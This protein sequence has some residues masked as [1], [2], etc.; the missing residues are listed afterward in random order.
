[1]RR[2][3][4]LI[5]SIV[6][7]LGLISV[8]A[9]ASDTLKTYGYD[10]INNSGGD[11]VIGFL[12]GSITVADGDSGYMGWHRYA[13]RVTE[14]FQ[15][16]YPNKT[17]KQVNAGIGGTGS[18]L[19]K[20]RVM[21]D[22]GAYAPDVVFVEYAV[23]DA[24]YSRLYGESVRSNMETIVRNLQSLPKVPVIVFLYSMHD[25]SYSNLKYTSIPDHQEVADYYDIETINF[26][27]Y[28]FPLVEKGEFIWDKNKVSEGSLTND[29][30]HPNAL[31]HEQYG[32]Y[33][34]SQ[35]ESRDILHKNNTGLSRKFMYTTKDTRD[36]K[37]VDADDFA[38]TGTWDNT[39]AGQSDNKYEAIQA[40]ATGDSISF[41]Y[42]S[43]GN[44]EIGVTALRGS[45]SWVIDEGTENELS[46]TFSV[47]DTNLPVVKSFVSGLAEGEHTVKVV[48]TA[49]GTT[50]PHLKLGR[51]IANG[52][53]EANLS[54]TAANGDHIPQSVPENLVIG[55]QT[56]NFHSD[57]NNG[58]VSYDPYSEDYTGNDSYTVRQLTTS[59][60]LTA[61]GSWGCH[62]FNFAKATAESHKGIL[63]DNYTATAGT[64]VFKARV[65]TLAGNPTIG[66]TT[67]K[68]WVPTYD[69]VYGKDG[70]A[71]GAEWE[72]YKTTLSPTADG[73]TLA[74]GH[75][76]STANDSFLIDVGDGVYFAPEVAYDVRV[77][78][79]GIA[80]E[81]IAG[82]K[83]TYKAELINQIEIPATSIAQD[84]TWSVVDANGAAVEGLTVSAGASTNEA[85]VFAAADV[86]VGTYY[87]KAV[88]TPTLWQKTL[89]IEVVEGAPDPY[90]RDYVP[91]E[92]PENKVVNFEH[93][94]WISNTQADSKAGLSGASW[95]NGDNWGSAKITALED[96][97]SVSSYY[98]S[99]GIY[100][101]TVT[102]AAFPKIEMNS[103]DYLE[104][105]HYVFM[106][107]ARNGNTDIKDTKLRI[108][109]WNGT[110]SGTATDFIPVQE[111]EDGIV[112][113]PD[114]GEWVVVKVTLPER[115]T[116]AAAPSIRMG[117]P[118][119][120]A[121]GTSIELNSKLAG[122]QQAYYAKEVP[123]SVALAGVDGDFVATGG[124]AAFKA[125]LLNQLGLTGYLDQTNVTFT[126]GDAR[127]NAVDGLTVTSSGATATV[128][129]ADDVPEGAYYLRANY[130]I[131]A[132]TTW[133]KTIQI[134]V[135]GAIAN[136]SDFIQPEKPE[137][138]TTYN[139]VGG[140]NAGYWTASGVPE[141]MA[142]GSVG[143]ATKLYMSSDRLTGADSNWFATG[144]FIADKNKLTA[145]KESLKRF[146][147]E[148]NTDYVFEVKARSAEGN[149]KLGI[150]NNDT[151]G[152]Y[153]TGSHGAEGV[154]IGTEWT[155]FKTTL[156]TVDNSAYK[157]N[158]L[159]FGIV[160]GNATD[161]IV[162]DPVSFYLA[163]EVAYEFNVTANAD[164]VAQG[165]SMVLSA[166]L[167]NQIGTE[168]TLS[169][170]FDWVAVTDDRTAYIDG[171]TF[172][173]DADDAS[174]V[175]VT[176][177]DDVAPGE[178]LIVA[179]NKK[180]D[181]SR[182]YKLTVV[183]P[184]FD[185]T[186]LKLETSANGASL[187]AA[188]VK[189]N[190][191]VVIILAAFRDNLLAKS[192]KAILT[193]AGGVA[194]LSEAIELSGL[195]SGDKV[196]VFVWDEA[197]APFSMK[198]AYKQPVVI[199]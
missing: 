135:A 67:V 166:Q 139:Q 56:P 14:W 103:A 95:I 68:S 128:S 133:T 83:N 36:I 144:I 51:I 84:F 151:W 168:G 140:A 33:I 158:Y 88:S 157:F 183:E 176:V 116:G 102:D 82:G 170:E 11:L 86:P 69:N 66:A 110:Y 98:G 137:N 196:R 126:V 1:M 9:F 172:E 53:V 175:V 142:A 89:A 30:I 61:G 25:N 85:T 195:E 146:L 105:D 180:E 94:F 5:L 120:S 138:L 15:E 99:A 177:A 35:L 96:I 182:H 152:R 187:S 54:S 173:K 20:Y 129:A 160:T 162:V 44:D 185:V 119:G 55:C 23:N 124:K 79:T 190:K 81:I 48:N 100:I 46:G 134:N 49:D 104:G 58:K 184:S 41:K 148:A 125:Q 24:H 122:L 8:P 165:E 171:I 90:A 19:G 52:G 45:G 107:A 29:N 145:E 109:V 92:M 43:S 178:Y 10:N 130:A 136:T 12:G 4:S 72:D 17:V 115:S 156:S 198:S 123:H 2:L 149:V 18:D 174:K 63:Y 70:F 47:S 40:T 199:E 191:N 57:R 189:S 37:F 147:P 80:N 87:L 153:V 21:T 114:S 164:S 71:P 32:N 34:I 59:A 50:V 62:G 74:F 27:S 141:D 42:T 167:L 197:L 121:E 3:L 13:T 73:F 163:K 97:T 31:G 194:T 155:D 16:K 91:G 22:I 181:V 143:S 106:F 161:Y 64:Y 28:M 77:K 112:S 169:Q 75:L 26:Y 150:A 60:D 38:K 93:T 108:G 159:S 6:I 192:E 65:R 132:D 179:Q 78:T 111:Y 101:K 117:L 7:V 113:L 131:D 193:P 188:S 186:E 39:Y 118:V 127:G 76:N 154:T